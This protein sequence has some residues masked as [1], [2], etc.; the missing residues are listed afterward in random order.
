MAIVVRKSSHVAVDKIC[1]GGAMA[2]GSEG[3]LPPIGVLHSLFDEI[4]KQENS[5]GATDYRCIYIQLTPDSVEP[6][7]NP[8]IKILSE[9]ETIISLGPL[10]K[11]VQAEA[12]ATESTAPSGVTFY[13]QTEINQRNSTG[14]L[15]FPGTST[16]NPG[17]YCGL[18]IKRRT[19]ATS[20]SGSI[21]EELVLDLEYDQ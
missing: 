4:T 19:N 18:W 13:T 14:Y 10:T 7:G 8:R 2:S 16:L 1:C 9:S 6:I 5:T 21:T 15:S 3:I 20:G 17:E 11:N 12:I